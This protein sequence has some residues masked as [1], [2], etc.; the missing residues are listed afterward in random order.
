ML[1]MHQTRTLCRPTPHSWIKQRP[2]RRVVWLWGL[3]NMRQFAPRMVMGDTPMSVPPHAK[4]CPNRHTQ[5]PELSLPRAQSCLALCLKA[6]SA[7]AAAGCMPASRAHVPR[8]RVWHLPQTV[9]PHQTRHV[10][11]MMRLLRHAGGPGRKPSP[12]QLPPAPKRAVA[13]AVVPHGS[14]A[15]HSVVPQRCRVGGGR[16]STVHVACS[17]PRCFAR[18]TRASAPVRNC[19]T[20]AARSSITCPN[21][22]PS[23]FVCSAPVTP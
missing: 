3:R 20:C 8:L 17:R 22:P 1:F 9:A 16:Q 18:R 10:Q 23:R 14:T 19:Q 15:Q 21:Y 6:A 13:G 2:G 7:A 5:V 4:G 11:S 12:C